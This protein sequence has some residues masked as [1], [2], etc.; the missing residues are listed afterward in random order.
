[1]HASAFFLAIPA[2]IVLIAVSERAAARTAASIYAASLL[3]MF[4]MS[5][6]YHRLAKS[7]AARR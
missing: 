7:D 1:M 2:G 5:A 3:I 4:G 6:A